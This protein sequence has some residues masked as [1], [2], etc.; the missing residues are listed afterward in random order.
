MNEFNVLIGNWEESDK[1][2][3]FGPLTGQEIWVVPNHDS[4]PQLLKELELFSSNSQARK[5]GWDG[6]VAHGFSDLTIGKKRTRVTILNIR[7]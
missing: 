6:S 3:F 1:E 2:L 4:M 7:D 5:A